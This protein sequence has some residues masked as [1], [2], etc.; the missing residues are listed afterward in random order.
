MTCCSVGSSP[1]TSTSTSPP[2]PGPTRPSAS[3]PAGPTRSG[4]RASA[5][6]PSAPKHGERA[7][8]ITTH[9]A[10]AYLPDSRKPEVVFADAHRGRPARAATS[11]STPW[12]STLTEPAARRPLRRRRRP[13]RRRLRTPLAPEESFGDDPLRM[14]RA[15][16]FIAGYGLEPDAGA[17]RRRR[18]RWPTA[19]AIVSAERIRDELDKLLVG[20]RPVRR[21]VVRRRHRPRRPVPARAAGDARSSRTRSTATRTCSPTPSRWS[22]RRRPRAASCGSPRCCTTSASRKTRAFGP[23][24]RDASTTTRWSARAWPAT[25]MQA[26]RYPND[27]IE[28][29]SRLV[30]LHLRFHTYAHGLD[31]Q[32]GAPLRA[33]RRPAARRAHRADPLRLHDPQRAQGAPRSP[34]AWTSSRRASPSW[35]RRR[36]WRRSGPTSTARQ[37]MAHLGIEPG[38]DVGEALDFLLELRLDEGPLGEDEAYR[39][40]P[41]AATLR[42]RQPEQHHPEHPMAK[43]ARQGEGR[44]AADARRQLPCLRPPA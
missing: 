35:R 21:A 2:T 32:R 14:L 34:G 16:R 29:V 9:R 20:R 40:P 1:A 30:F 33:R 22:P 28:A 11:R 3:W 13:G 31:R 10:E 15:A 41:P 8:E 36:S 26:L 27:D 43:P 24:G 17:G 42:R 38:R 39:R 6:A 4:R 44:P 12:R 7:F 23:T 18:A 37:V 25:G 19:S 5:S